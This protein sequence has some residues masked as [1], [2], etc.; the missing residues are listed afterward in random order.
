MCG[1]FFPEWGP[2]PPCLCESLSGPPSLPDCLSR[3]FAE[4]VKAP[5][6]VLGSGERFLARITVGRRH[7]GVVSVPA[8]QRPFG[9]SSECTVTAR[10][11]VGVAE[12][13]ALLVFPHL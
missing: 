3:A 11:G 13:K 2:R 1:A 5:L 4:G 8:F 12:G 9:A 7:N 10:N 6:F